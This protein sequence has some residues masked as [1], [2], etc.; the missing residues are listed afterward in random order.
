MSRLNNIRNHSN[1]L[2]FIISKIL[3]RT[4]LCKLFTITQD[5]YVLKF[6][7]TALARDKWIDP[8]YRHAAEDNF[9]LDYARFDRWHCARGCSG[10]HDRGIWPDPH[11]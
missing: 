9:F 5:H 8:N 3:I 6:H 1:P 10:F 7:P 2:K 11:Q 4:K